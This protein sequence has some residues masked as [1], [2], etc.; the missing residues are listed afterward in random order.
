MLF[1]VEPSG[2][3]SP[4]M[5]SHVADGEA[6]GFGWIAARLETTPEREEAV[7]L[8]EIEQVATKVLVA[9]RAYFR[10]RRFRQVTLMNSECAIRSFKTPNTAE[11]EAYFT[12]LLESRIGV[13]RRY[14]QWAVSEN[15]AATDRAITLVTQAVNEASSKLDVEAED[16]AQHLS[17][18]KDDLRV[19]CVRLREDQDPVMTYASKNLRDAGSGWF[20]QCIGK[21]LMTFPDVSFAGWM[22]RHFCEV[23]A[24]EVERIHQVSV[25]LDFETGQS[26]RQDYIRGIVPF[27]KRGKEHALLTIMADRQLD[28]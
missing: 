14:F 10:K 7:C 13:A 21:S 6:S 8:L 22:H 15:A 23:A 18:R 9:L 16:C 4:A 26:H 17:N 12:G 28:D 1:V 27:H 25:D 20:S 3:F 19:A 2:V 11:I 24:D 5:A